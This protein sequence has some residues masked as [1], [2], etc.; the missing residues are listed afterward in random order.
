MENTEQEKLEKIKS[1]VISYISL[2]IVKDVAFYNSTCRKGIEITEEDIINY[3]SK[4]PK[5]ESLGAK[6]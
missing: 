1:Y 2:G 6:L 3:I 4:L 5:N